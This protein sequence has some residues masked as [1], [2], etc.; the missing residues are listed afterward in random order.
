MALGPTLGGLLVSRTGNLLSVFYIS[1]SLH[2]AYFLAM[3]FF[4]P[5]SLSEE[6]RLVNIENA[7]RRAEQKRVEIERAEQEDG[8]TAARFN[9]LLKRI[10]FFLSPLA[11][12][13]PRKQPGPRGREWNL[14]IVA[15]VYGLVM[16]LLVSY[17]YCSTAG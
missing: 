10:F 11:I 5:E 12:F 3:L 4:V 6:A 14:T 7:K 16:L 1:A 2:A 13:L 15:V 9:R 8:S 17:V